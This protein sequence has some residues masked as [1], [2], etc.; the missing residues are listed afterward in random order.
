[1]TRGQAELERFL[2]DLSGEVVAI[3]PNVTKAILGAQI[4]FLLVVERVP[5]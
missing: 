5:D 1:M 2:N 3:I 4:D